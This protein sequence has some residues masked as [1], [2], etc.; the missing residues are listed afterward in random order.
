[1]LLSILHSLT[2]REKK[3]RQHK[4]QLLQIA[5]EHDK[6]RNLEKVQRYR[7]PADMKKGEKGENK[8]QIYFQISY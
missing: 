5:H 4:K 7:M 6:A 1:M 8:H 2:E 3:D